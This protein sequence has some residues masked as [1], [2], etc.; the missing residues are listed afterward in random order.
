MRADDTGAGPGE[1]AAGT[2]G[3]GADT[4]QSGAGITVRNDAGSGSYEAVLG[5][6]VVGRVI[7]QRRD[8]RVIIRHT[9]VDPEFQGRGVATDLVRKVLD[10]VAANGWR[11]TSY[12]S[13]VTAFL[14][15]HPGYAR[16]LDAR[17]PGLSQA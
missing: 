13:F 5:G 12:C 16:L 2:R 11:L 4:G 3:P 17:Q 6:R 1:P 7:Y 14:A 9:I 15:R 8:A 10:D